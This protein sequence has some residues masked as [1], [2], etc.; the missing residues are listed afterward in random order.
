MQQDAAG[1]LLPR[2]MPGK[3]SKL[4]SSNSKREILRNEALAGDSL[5][6]IIIIIIIIIII[7]LIMMAM[8]VTS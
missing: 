2:K 5:L 7:M 3:M 1:S 8:V 6:P 4:Q